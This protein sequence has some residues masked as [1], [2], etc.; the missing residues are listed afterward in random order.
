MTLGWPTR[1]R[2]PPRRRG[3]RQLRRRPLSDPGPA[4]A[5][6]PWRQPDDRDA[7]LVVRSHPFVGRGRP[8]DVLTNRPQQPRGRA[9]VAAGVL[10]EP[11]S[12]LRGGQGTCQSYVA[13]PADLE[14]HPRIVEDVAE[15][16]GP[17]RSGSRRMPRGGHHLEDHLARPPAGAPG[18]GQEQEP[19]AKESPEP[20]PVEQNG[21]PQQRALHPVRG[22][23]ENIM[24]L[25]PRGSRC[26]S[27]SL[28]S[29]A[30]GNQASASGTA[31]TVT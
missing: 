19:V 3:R 28:I 17:R 10:G 9:G 2:G 5:R 14:A 18:V 31:T 4:L 21:R 16:L 29:M 23:W 30:G 25:P 11:A 13:A 26:A 27:S 6:S 8:V 24:A 22:G 20:Q 15:P 7:V 12:G 1:G